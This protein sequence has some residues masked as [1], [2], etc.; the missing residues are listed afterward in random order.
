M[1]TKLSLVSNLHTKAEFL[2]CER[3]RAF[4]QALDMLGDSGR[5]VTTICTF[6]PSLEATLD[7]LAGYLL[8]IAWHPKHESLL[9][10]CLAGAVAATASV[11]GKAR[12]R[13]HYR[14]F[15]TGL[16]APLGA[17]ASQEVWTYEAS[18]PDIAPNGIAQPPDEQGLD[19][20]DPSQEPLEEWRYRQAERRIRVTTSEKPAY[21]ERTARLI[22]ASRILESR[23]LILLGDPIRMLTGSEAQR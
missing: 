15:L 20:W 23:D 3:D 21:P 10:A 17:L 19:V 5:E 9:D 18:T 7:R 14:A 6:F 2:A 4:S 22:L 13:R 12:T 11:P 1:T 16:F 8:R